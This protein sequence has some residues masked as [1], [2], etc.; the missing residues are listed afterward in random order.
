MAWAVDRDTNG[1]RYIFELGPTRRGSKCNCKCPSC[2]LSLIAVNAGKKSWKR[3]PHFRHPEGAAREK[4]VIIAARKALEEMFS[5]QQRIVLPRRR[6]SQQVEGLSGKYFDAWVERPAETVGITQCTFQDETKA[7]LTLDDGRRLIVQLIGRGEIA[8][9]EGADLLTARIE[10]NADDPAI[11]DMAPEEIFARLELAWSNACWTRH[12]S[13]A[14]LDNEAAANARADAANALDWLDEDGLPEGVRRETLLHREVKAILER[15]RRICVPELRVEARWQR[16]DEFVDA[17]AWS[18]PA[19]EIALTSVEL[20]V[21]LGHSVPDVVVTWVEADNWTRSMLIEVTVTNPITEERIER[22]SSFGWPALE[23]DIGRMGGTVT[24]EEF[25]RL[26]VEEVAG[27]RWLYHPTI[28]E[29]KARLVAA[30]KGEETRIVEAERKRQAILDVPAA[31]WAKRYLEAFQ[32]RWQVQLPFGD[33]LPDTEDWRQAQ[34]NVSE[35]IH[36]LAEHGYP[37]SFMDQS[38]LRTI[39]ARILSILAGAGIEYKFNDVWGV[40][41]AIL[42]DG[43]PTKQWHTL[44][45]IALKTFPPSLTGIHQGKVDAWRYDVVASIRKEEET[46]I[47]E[48]TYDRLIGLLFPEMRSALSEPFGTP[49][50]IQ[51]DVRAGPKKSDQVIVDSFAKTP[52]RKSTGSG[53]ADSVFTTFDPF[54]SHPWVTDADKKPL[55]EAASAAAKHGISPGEFAHSYEIPGESLDKNK[56]FQLLIDGGFAKTRYEWSWEWDRNWLCMWKRK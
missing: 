7:I 20:E 1:P 10:I 44:Y 17:S 26:V 46:Y 15:E 38:P 50:Y 13:D 47:R 8:H 53:K 21:H 2:G 42:C 48:T 5:R 31:Q 36:A 6:R 30:M 14:E 35:A 33:G 32:R 49:L 43:I 4:C 23:I 40:I 3:R 41:N 12:W 39:V 34:V 51:N 22:L 18:S 54:E 9:D 16:G 28:E 52:D 25:T 45:L 55:L 29:E 24:R 37:A 27:K 19:T 56:T 11:A